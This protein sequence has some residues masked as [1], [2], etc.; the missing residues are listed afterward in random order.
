MNREEVLLDL[1]RLRRPVAVAAAEL[2]SFPW[3][4]EE[5]VTLT[6]ADALR[7][8][9]TFLA[10]EM[11]R[12]DCET[13]ADALEVRDD[14]GLESAF[15]TELRQFLFEVANPALEGRLTTETAAEWRALL[16]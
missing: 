6:R 8:V 10:G 4:S 13:W 5:L 14:V 16:T 2:R 12:Q 7:V 3:D 1:I 9:D 15:R 11:S